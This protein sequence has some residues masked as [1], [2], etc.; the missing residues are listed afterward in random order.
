MSS[1]SESSTFDPHLSHIHPEPIV[2]LNPEKKKI[3]L[4]GEGQQATFVSTCKYEGPRPGYIYK[5]GRQGRGYYIDQ[6]PYI[7]YQ[8]ATW[9]RIQKTHAS[10]CLC[11]TQQ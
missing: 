2:K 1:S 8:Q 7:D 9:R 5:E 11:V 6:G 4:R 3:Q 10:V